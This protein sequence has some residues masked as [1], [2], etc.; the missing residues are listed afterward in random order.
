MP[1]PRRQL[2][3]L[4]KAISFTT[5][6]PR[7]WRYERAIKT[8]YQLQFARNQEIRQ[9]AEEAFKKGVAYGRRCFMGSLKDERERYYC[10]DGQIYPWSNQ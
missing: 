9:R 4:E 5:N 2:E 3:R 6:R 10:Q 8:L 7:Y 1:L